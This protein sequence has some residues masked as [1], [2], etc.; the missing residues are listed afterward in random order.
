MSLTTTPA[1]ISRLVTTMRAREKPLVHTLSQPQQWLVAT[2][3]KL[4][5]PVMRREIEAYER[6]MGQDAADA[7]RR[8]LRGKGIAA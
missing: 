3:E 6:N 4:S 1:E 8:A 5:V 2:L 7:V